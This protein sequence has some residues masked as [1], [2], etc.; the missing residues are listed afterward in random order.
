M[1]KTITLLAVVALSLGAAE[2][3]PLPSGK[4]EFAQDKPARAGKVETFMPRIE[5]NAIVCGNKRLDLRNDSG[6]TLSCDGEVMGRFFYY[7][8][9]DDKATKKQYWIECGRWFADK[10]KSSFRKEGNTFFAD[11][12]MKIGDYPSWEACKQQVELLPDGLIKIDIQWMP[13]EDQNLALKG[14][15]LFF[16]M[17]YKTGGGKSITLNGS[18]TMLPM[19]AVAGSICGEYRPKEFK[20]VF[21]PDDPGKTFTITAV[22]PDIDLF[23]SWAFKDGLRFN[24]LD[25]KKTRHLTV[26]LDIR[27]GVKKSNHGYGGGD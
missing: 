26:F 27:Q 13:P 18:K 23:N 7:F 12:F 8:T 15:S 1:K 21:L 17:P 19:E 24:F 3:L 4:A 2:K 22:K 5:G 25:N 9:G 20:I 10:E 11:T 16:M 14:H 6:M